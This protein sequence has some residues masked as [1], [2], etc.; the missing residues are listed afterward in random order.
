MIFYRFRKGRNITVILGK[1]LSVPES[2]VIDYVGPQA[3]IRIRDQKGNLS[4]L[5]F[6]VHGSLRTDFIRHISFERH[7]PLCWYILSGS[8]LHAVC[9]CTRLISCSCTT[10]FG[11]F[12]CSIYLCSISMFFFSQALLKLHPMHIFEVGV[13]NLACLFIRWVD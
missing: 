9:F 8:R 10:M 12:L 7:L 2:F 11:F 3:S 4:M 1:V 6:F 5:L 13:T